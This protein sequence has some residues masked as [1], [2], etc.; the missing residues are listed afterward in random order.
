MNTDAFVTD[1]TSEVQL[2]APAGQ[3]QGQPSLSVLVEMLPMIAASLTSDG[4]AILSGILLDER[5]MMLGVLDDG[6]WDVTAEDAEGLW[7]SAR[8]ARR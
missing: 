6:G 5:D 4:E 3:T 2:G 1:P 7:W 8:I